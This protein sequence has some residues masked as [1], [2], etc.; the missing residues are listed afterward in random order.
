MY[1]LLA[2]WAMAFAIAY[3]LA[4]VACLLLGVDR[5]PEMANVAITTVVVVTLLSGDLFKDSGG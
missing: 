2:R 1:K 3:L 4:I 5:P